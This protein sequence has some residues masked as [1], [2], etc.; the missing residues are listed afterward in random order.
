MLPRDLRRK[1]SQ[2]SAQPSEARL[3]SGT[4]GLRGSGHAP[5]G[6]ESIPTEVGTPAGPPPDWYSDAGSAPF[7]FPAT[8]DDTSFEG[9]I[10]GAKSACELGDFWLTEVAADDRWAATRELWDRLHPP[11]AGL[12]GDLSE[13]TDLAPSDLLFL[14]IET[15]GLS[16]ATL[17]LVGTLDFASGRPMLRFHFARDYA[18]EEPMLHAF[19]QFMGRFRTV[20]TFNGR[21]F[22]MPFLRDR[23]A[24]HR[25]RHRPPATHIDALHAARRRWRGR[26]AD[27]RLQTLEYELCGRLRHGDLPGHLIPDVYH[28]FVATGRA[29]MLVPIF[30]H[31]ALDLITLAEL[32][33]LELTTAPV[34]P[35]ARRRRS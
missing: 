34:P 21:S 3:Q 23:M 25:L 9:L 2:L 18:E 4:D 22:D 16:N 33:A 5:S 6:K 24:Y 35:Q 14:D 31:N 32:L 27:C 26:F 10:G 29:G 20:V 28:E 11:A 17:F 1:L 7:Y 12:P 8:V 13:M 30:Q 15:A 19:Q